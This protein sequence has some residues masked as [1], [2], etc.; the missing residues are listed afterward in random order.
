MQVK[1]VLSFFVPVIVKFHFPS[2]HLD[3]NDSS[4][5]KCS[6]TDSTSST[7]RVAM[8][9]TRLT[10]DLGGELGDDGGAVALGCAGAQGEGVSG[11]GVEACEHVGGLVA[12][13]HYFPTLV[14]EVKLGVKG[15][16]CLVGDLGRK[17]GN[18]EYSDGGLWY[19]A[20]R[21]HANK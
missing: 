9:L 20:L 16:H 2:S 17:E 1:W 5:S 4:G 14:G 13:L 7:H 12:Q 19:S 10:W 8:L 3:L 6:T 11:A 15:A 21:M 18:D